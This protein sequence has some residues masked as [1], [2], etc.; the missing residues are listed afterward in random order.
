[1]C[2]SNG[3]DHR[4]FAV[5]ALTG[6]LPRTSENSRYAKF[7]LSDLHWDLAYAR[8]HMLEAKVG[9]L[10]TLDQR[11]RTLGPWTVVPQGA[12]QEPA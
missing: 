11:E 10:A 2:L 1:M 4:R 3:G 6:R 12:A 9:R 5:R 8:E 7:A